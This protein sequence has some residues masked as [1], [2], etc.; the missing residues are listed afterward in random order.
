MFECVSFHAPFHP[1]ICNKSDGSWPLDSD[2]VRCLNDK[3]IRVKWNL[4]KIPSAAHL[5]LDPHAP[6]GAAQSSSSSS[7]MLSKSNWA[8]EGI[9]ILFYFFTF[10]GST[11]SIIRLCWN[12]LS[13]T[14]VSHC[15]STDVRLNQWKMENMLCD[16][17]TKMYISFLFFYSLISVWCE[18]VDCGCSTKSAIFKHFITLQC[19]VEYCKWCSEHLLLVASAQRCHHFVVWTIFVEIRMPVK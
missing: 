9:S 15:H 12:T 5:S 6:R 8:P 10:F 19:C 14:P 4:W 18:T 3:F 17:R 2:D 11:E 1:W 7:R 13:V 16:S